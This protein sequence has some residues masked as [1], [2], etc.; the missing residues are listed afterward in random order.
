MLESF[1]MNE[2]VCVDTDLLSSFDCAREDATIEPLVKGQQLIA[3]VGTGDKGRV[4]SLNPLFDDCSSGVCLIR[5]ADLC[6]ALQQACA[7]IDP[8]ALFM[9]CSENCNATLGTIALCA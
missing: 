8:D 6:R 2:S 3:S 1:S 7:S 4:T 5:F 9:T